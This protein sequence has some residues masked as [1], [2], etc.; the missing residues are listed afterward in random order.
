MEGDRQWMGSP[1]AKFQAGLNVSADYEGVDFTM[2]WQTSYGN[3][4]FN[5]QRYDLL[6]FDVD[7]FPADVKPWTWDNPSTDQPRPYAGPSENRKAQTDRYLEDGSY[8]RLK[9]LQIGYSLPTNWLNTV[10]LSRCRL[11]LSAQNLLTIT[12]YKGYDPEVLTGDVFGQGNDHGAYPPV[13]SYNIGL[14]VS[15]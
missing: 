3:K 14:Q 1:F 10:S 7:N 12:K 4:I 13:R 2:F 6:K 15:F 8:L 11:Y 5:A 9:N